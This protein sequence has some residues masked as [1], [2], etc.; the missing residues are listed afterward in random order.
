MPEKPIALINLILFILFFLMPPRAI[1]GFFD[2]LDNR[3]N[4]T[5]PKFFL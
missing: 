5:I 3:L 1:T 4:L 2:I